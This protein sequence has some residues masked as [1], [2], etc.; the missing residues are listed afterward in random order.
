MI[1]LYCF[2]RRSIRCAFSVFGISTRAK[3][4][5]LLVDIIVL[6]IFHFLV[7]LSSFICASFQ[8]T[9]LIKTSP[10]PVSSGISPLLFL[11]I[12]Y[13]PIGFRLLSVLCWRLF[14]ISYLILLLSFRLGFSF[15]N[16]FFLL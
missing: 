12:I 7:I 8:I 13:L 1:S 10:R 11:F 14:I 16:L 9:G 2:W 5:I 4:L 15:V 6:E 3:I